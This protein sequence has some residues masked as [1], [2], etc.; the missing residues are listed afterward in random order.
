VKHRKYD[1]TAERLGFR[2]L[3]L[4]VETTGGMAP[5]AVKLL[6]AMVEASQ[7]QLGLWDADST[8][9]HLHSLLAIDLSLYAEIVDSSAM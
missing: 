6:E 2:L 5:D 3:P 7:E 9:T 1:E 4:A 8:S